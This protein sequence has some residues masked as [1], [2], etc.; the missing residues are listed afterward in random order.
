MDTASV[1]TA[2]NKLLSM[3]MVMLNG[4]WHTDL[5]IIEQGTQRNVM[6]GYGCSYEVPK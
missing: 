3:T 5:F 1:E 4:L 2:L 6:E